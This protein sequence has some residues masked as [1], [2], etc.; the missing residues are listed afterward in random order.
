MKLFVTKMQPMISYISATAARVDVIQVVKCSIA[1]ITNCIRQTPRYDINRLQYGQNAF[2]HAGD[3][4]DSAEL[5]G[6]DGE[7]ASCFYHIK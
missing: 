7:S 6:R 3:R 4:G 1:R 2:Y 5:Y